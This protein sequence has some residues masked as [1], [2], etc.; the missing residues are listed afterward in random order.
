M[1]D[2]KALSDSDAQLAR[3]LRRWE[4]E[5]GTLSGP[6]LAASESNILKCLGAAVVLTWNDLPQPLQRALFMHALQ[7]NDICDPE[8]LKAQIGRFLHLHKDDGAFNL[9]RQQRL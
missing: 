4:G 2:D 3:A 8:T 1:V 6:H 5:G 7:V 9:E